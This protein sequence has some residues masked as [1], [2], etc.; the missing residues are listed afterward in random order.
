[1]KDI[2]SGKGSGIVLLCRA[3]FEG[4]CAAEIQ[5]KTAELGVY[6]YC[7]TQPDQAYVTYNC[8]HEEAE[9][10]ARKLSLK[11]LVFAREMFALLGPVKLAGIEDRASEV[12]D[13]LKPHRETFGLAGE[14]RVET[15]D[16]NEANQ[17]SKFCRK[18]SVPLRQAL[19]KEELLSNK[20]LAKRPML[21]V[22]FVNSAHAL[23]GYSYSY[24]Q[25]VHE[26]GIVRLR[27]PKEAPS[28]STLKLDEAFQ[29]FVP[30]NEQEKRVHSGMK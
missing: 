19:R 8:Q 27:M 28:R 12:I 29:V 10:I 23:V 21:H 15:P 4:D 11:D 7:Q 5:D 16:T 14:L 1:M 17:L 2:V 18:F 26:G 9:H 24:N 13:V 6:G 3:G 20:P 22:L 25:T 30:E